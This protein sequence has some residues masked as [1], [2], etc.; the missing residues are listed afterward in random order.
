MKGI[1]KGTN[2]C[3]GE[4]LNKGTIQW[5]IRLVKF[6]IKKMKGKL[7]M[8]KELNKDSTPQEIL[9]HKK[10][11]KIDRA[12]E[13]RQAQQ[14]YAEALTKTLG[15]LVDAEELERIKQS[16]DPHGLRNMTDEQIVEKYNEEY[17][18]SIVEDA[19]EERK[20]RNEDRKAKVEKDSD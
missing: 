9:E 17:P 12:K 2:E 18:D 5:P 7:N 6:F 16:L 20:K 1:E 4:A 15:H 13:G 11:T 14:D 3:S 8:T 19:L 10:A